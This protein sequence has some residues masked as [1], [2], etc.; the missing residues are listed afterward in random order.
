MRKLYRVFQEG[1]FVSTPYPGLY[2]GITTQKIFGRLDCQSGKRNAKAK[3]RI[4][5]RFWDDAIEAGYRPCRKC[6]PE[7]RRRK[8]CD[9]MPHGLT[10]G[11][12]LS[13]TT[14]R[15][16]IRISCTLCSKVLG[17]GRHDRRGR[18]KWQDGFI[19]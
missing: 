5:F 19:V 9:H 8:D 12:A 3:N 2:A 15:V 6:K 10:G 14:L 17:Y 7:C 4:F 1:K 13:I 18:I 11:L 16:R